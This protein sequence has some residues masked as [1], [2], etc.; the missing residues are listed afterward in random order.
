MTDDTPVRVKRP[1][2]ETII[3]PKG[4]RMIFELVGMCK[5]L[6]LSA[7]R[8]IS[9]IRLTSLSNSPQPQHVSKS[10]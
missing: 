1:V 10:G 2:E 6:K 3:L 9:Y 4:S 8:G 7:S 5:R